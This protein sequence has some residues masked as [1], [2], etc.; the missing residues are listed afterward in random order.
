MKKSANRNHQKMEMAGLVRWVL[1][2]ATI[3]AIGASFVLVRN[4]HVSDGDMILAYEQ[5]IRSLDR[6]IEM[7][8]LRVDG[9]MNRDEIAGVLSRYGSALKPVNAARVLTIRPD[10]NVTAPSVASAR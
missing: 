7:L 10:R 2:A 8:E 6:E 5:E 4:R 1:L 9:Q 3:G